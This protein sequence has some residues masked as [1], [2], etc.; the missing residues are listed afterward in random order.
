MEF[1]GMRARHHAAGKRSFDTKGR[2]AGGLAGSSE[3]VY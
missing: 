3:K 2:P 1:D